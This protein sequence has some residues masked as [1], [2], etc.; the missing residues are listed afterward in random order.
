MHSWR[1]DKHVLVDEAEHNIG[2]GVIRSL[3]RAGYRVTACSSDPHALGFSSR[4]A[5]RAEVCPSPFQRQE[6]LRWL[7]GTIEAQSIDTIIATE[8][9]LTAIQPRYS[10]YAHLLP[11]GVDHNVLYSA[12]SKYRLVGGFLD[13]AAPAELQQHI[14]PSLLVDSTRSA[15]T[16]EQLRG[17]RLP[18]YVKTDFLSSPV[19][20]HSRVH[21]LHDYAAVSDLLATLRTSYDHFLVQGH[22]EGVGVGVFFVVRNGRVLARFMHRRLHEVPHTG[23]VSSYRRSW[24]HDAIHADA[25]ARIHHLRWE[26]PVML[27]Y[28]WDPRTDAFHLIELNCRFWGSLHLA[29]HAGV[30]FPRILVDSM[31]GHVDPVEP[32]FATDLRCRDTFPTEARHVG[33]LLRDD[34]I[35]IASK[36]WSVLRFIGLTLN[37]RVRADL[38]YPGDRGLYWRAAARYL[39]SMLASIGRRFRRA[40]A[41]GRHA[42]VGGAPSP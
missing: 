5:T 14:P 28:R 23:G 19:G 32:E 20:A 42:C 24:W 31:H 34:S 8:G 15:P 16:D 36:A 4:F 21:R 22:V 27:E 3:G 33:S 29:L 7:D 6:F 10:S 41:A 30:D 11:Y 9:L 39:R 1:Q 2:I 38:L 18:L 26:G 25:C 12:I 13:P 40:E 37:S 17:L 35:A